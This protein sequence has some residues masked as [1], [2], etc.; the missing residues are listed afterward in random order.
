MPNTKIKVLI[1]DDSVVMRQTLSHILSKDRQIK[2]IGTAAD[3]FIAAEMISKEPPDVITLDIEMPRMDGLTFLSKIMSQ[4]PIPTVIISRF[5]EKG[6][7]NAIRALEI[8]AIEVIDK[9]T[10]GA[11]SKTETEQHIIH[12]VKVASKAM[13]RRKNLTGHSTFKRSSMNDA[14]SLPS[15]Q[16]IAF[17]AS[18]GGTV[19]LASILQNMPP[20]CPGIVIVQHMPQA[21]TR[22]FAEH[23]NSIC[24]ITVKEAEDLTPILKGQALIAPGNQ[25]MTVINTGRHF[26]VSLNDA[27]AINRHK[28]SVDVLFY[29]LAECAASK[30]V[31]I[32]LTG[33]G[34][35]GS[36]GLLALK[37][38]GAMTIAQDENSCSVYGMP[39]EAIRLHAAEHILPL[40]EIAPFLIKSL[41]KK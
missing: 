39:K 5:T 27:E 19:A 34:T 22:S 4:R 30:S 23:L 37:Q 28:P 12:L 31:G 16:V 41:D 13:V 25:H 6:S 36:Q 40:S 3:P 24:Q 11:K 8:G 29:S 9:N 33:M 7:G 1:I 20:N 14:K 26:S 15:E 35:D 21:F 32:I 17:G 38:A 10:L 18:T 2:V